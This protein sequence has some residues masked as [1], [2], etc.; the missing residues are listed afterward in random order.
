MPIS[1]SLLRVLDISCRHPAGL[2]FNVAFFPLYP[3]AVRSLE[4]LLRDTFASAFVISNVSCLLAALV[5]LRLGG[6]GKG[7]R[8]GLRAAILLLASPGSHFLSYPYPEALF[9]LLTSLA[10][11]AI[12]RDRPFLAALPGALASAA[13]SAGVVVAF[14]LALGAWNRRRDLRALL[15]YSIATILSLAGTA[16]FALFCHLH[17]GDALAFAHIHRHY[18]RSLTLF[19]PFLAFFRFTVDP[20]YFVV[21][22]AVVAACVLIVWR[23]AAPGWLS[24]SAWFLLLLPLATGTLKAMIRYQ[25]TN[26]PLFVGVGRMWRGRFFEGMV[27]ACTLLMAFE[28]F[29]FGKGIGHY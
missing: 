8:A 26:V 6:A 13:R 19:G 17:Y 29:L 9:L 15:H 23:R 22:L 16:A 2:P 27:L 24:S 25:A 11:L 28:A 5:M 21:S 4:L 20:D 3:L 10:F 14:A 1:I 7:P 12:A 18:G